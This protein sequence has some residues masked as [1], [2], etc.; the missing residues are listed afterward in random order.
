[1]DDA[2]TWELIRTERTALVDTLGTL[3]PDQ[4][5]HPSLCAGWSVQMAAG[6]VVAGAEQ[7][8]PGFFKGMAVNG[9]RFNR[10]M[11]RD[12]RRIGAAGPSEIVE[13]L[14]A[15]TT[16]TNRPPAPVK[17][18]LGEVVV[19]GA[20]VR[21]PLGLEHLVDPNALIACLDL[22]KAANFP[23][24]T[25]K[26]IAGLHLVAPDVGWSHG[27]GPE[28]SGPGLELLLVMTGRSGTF[29]ALQGDGLP[30]LHD[31]LTPTA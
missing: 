21:R 7:T 25:K 30:I 15:R 24:G 4:W 1:M 10:M 20:D 2:R 12:A 13:R 19:H 14:R 11:D 5:A 18:V 23:V 3:T 29:E 31:R 16:T 8:T 27:D 26:R 28:V 17:T 9:F 22:Y 6:H